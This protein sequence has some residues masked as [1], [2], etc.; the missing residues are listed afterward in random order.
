MITIFPLVYYADMPSLVIFRCGHSKC[1]NK[2]A[3]I[4]KCLFE[5]SLYIL[6]LQGNI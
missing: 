1:L 6:Q 4:I 2:T 3:F 5:F